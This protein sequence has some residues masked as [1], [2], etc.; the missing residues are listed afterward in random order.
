MQKHFDLQKWFSFL[1]LFCISAIGVALATVVSNFLTKNMIQRDAIVSKEFIES[2]IE[3]ENTWSYFKEPY[4]PEASPILESFFNHL[5]HLPDVVRAN[6]YAQD[7]TVIWSSNKEFIGKK[8]GANPELE[9]TFAGELIVE[10][11]VV[12]SDEKP[13]HASFGPELMGKEI[14]EAY[15]PITDSRN[16]AIVG[17]VELYKSPAALFAAI[18]EGKHL[19]WIATSAGGVLLY[20]ALFWIVRRANTVIH[21]QQEKLI[22]SETMAAI[23]EMAS[24]VVHGIR[25]PLA[26]IRS[27]AEISLEEHS[28]SARESLAD[29]IVESD[30]MDRWLRELLLYS[31]ASCTPAALGQEVSNIGNVCKEHL[32]DFTNALEERGINVVDDIQEPLPRVV[33]S[34]I[35]LGQVLSTLLSNAFDAMPDEGDLKVVVRLE[36]SGR[37]VMVQISDSG[38]GLSETALINI[39][40]PTFSTKQKGLG[41]GL[42]LSKRIVNRYGGSLR[43]ESSEGKGT[44][45]TMRLPTAATM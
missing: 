6:V 18:E 15:L 41:L 42:A 10:I 5:A 28:E 1:S 17:V 44:I 37:A 3:A 34:A 43:I 26:A 33:G 25:N 35:A 11:G 13:E 39:F 27:S 9:E 16:N 21:G 23:G 45:A 12:G 4:A 14:I 19:V 8:L 32:E 22:Y 20:G 36:N 30:R 38:P 24:A 31:R 7:R 29:I 40:R 2:I